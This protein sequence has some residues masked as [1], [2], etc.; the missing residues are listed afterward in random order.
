MQDFMLDLETMSTC[1]DAA[2][3]AIGA[4]AFNPETCELGAPF[5]RA[6]NLQSAMDHGGKLDGATVTWWLKQSETARAGV[7]SDGSSVIFALKEF[8]LWLRHHAAEEDTRI[9]GNSSAFDN[10]ILA[11]AYRRACMPV[12]WPHWNDR[13][14]RTMKALRRDIT[15]ERTGT[16]HNALDDATSQA[17][18]LMAIF[19][20]MRSSAL[21]EAA[22]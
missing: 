13:C 14:Y 20:A 4:Q 5:Y 12:P 22:A 3:V 2:I 6:I 16:H 9:W 1:S 21:Q 7:S 11:N 17:V 15:L 19:K 18:H 8:G 10:V